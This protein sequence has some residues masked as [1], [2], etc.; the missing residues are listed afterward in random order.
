MIQLAGARRKVQITLDFC[1]ADI[2][3]LREMGRQQLLGDCE[4][5]VDSLSGRESC[6]VGIE[7]SER[8]LFASRLIRRLQVFA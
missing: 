2:G 4:S 8:V 3:H 7:A 1:D 6:L 5:I